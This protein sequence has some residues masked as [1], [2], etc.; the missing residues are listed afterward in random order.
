MSQ[1]GDR[2][3]PLRAGAIGF[4]A[5]KSILSILLPNIS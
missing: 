5:E 2:L 3:L 4:A 1:K